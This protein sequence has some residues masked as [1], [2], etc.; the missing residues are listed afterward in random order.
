MK[1]MPDPRII[2]LGLP[3]SDL[4]AVVLAGALHEIN[5]QKHYVLAKANKSSNHLV[6]GTIY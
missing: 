3:D 4:V 2:F 5:V 6:E 1:V